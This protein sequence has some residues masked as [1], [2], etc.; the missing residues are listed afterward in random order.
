MVPVAARDA[1]TAIKAMADQII[2]LE[3][4]RPFFSVGTYFDDFR[5]V[6]DDEVTEALARQGA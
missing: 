1:L 3:V 5:Q 6:S 4:P 2:C